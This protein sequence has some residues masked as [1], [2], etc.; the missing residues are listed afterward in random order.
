MTLLVL[1]PQPPRLEVHQCS[2][3]KLKLVRNT[4]FAIIK[5][6]FGVS[7]VSL[8]PTDNYNIKNEKRIGTYPQNVKREI[9]M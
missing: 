8:C 4:V 7:I 3:S 6:S 1:E 2:I 9:S 5:I